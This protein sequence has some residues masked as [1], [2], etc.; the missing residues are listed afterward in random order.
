MGLTE[1]KAGGRWVVEG[2]MT[3]V[4]RS[5]ATEDGANLGPF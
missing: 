4:V 3:G 2:D 5:A 1:V